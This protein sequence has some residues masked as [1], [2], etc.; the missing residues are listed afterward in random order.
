VVITRLYGGLGNQMFQYAA[1]VALAARLGTRLL[2][3]TTWFEPSRHP[4]GP[5]RRYEL[6][7]FGVDDGMALRDRLALRLRRPAVFAETGFAPYRPAFE[8]LRGNVVLDGYWQSPRYFAGHEREV[9]EVFAFPAIVSAEG[10]RI[11]ERIGSRSGTVAVHVRR[12][13]YATNEKI[14]R[15][16]GLLPTAY[17]EAAAAHICARV[18]NPRFFIFSDDV[19]WCREALRLDGDVAFVEPRAAAAYEDM[20]LMALCENHVIAN[21]SYSW[22]GA[23]LSANA[24]KVVVA[25]ERWFNDPPPDTSDLIPAE[26]VEL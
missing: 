2:A 7:A 1:G 12:G 19:D 3:D 23:W 6:G 26:W 11:A 9:R 20:A 14:R 25:P 17:Y 8:S 4:S 21:S 18:E 15:I 16:F 22:W 5:S 24:A 13:D 10:R